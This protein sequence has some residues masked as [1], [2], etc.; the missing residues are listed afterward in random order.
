MTTKLDEIFV[1]FTEEVEDL[2]KSHSKDS[3]SYEFEASY[4]ILMQEFGRSVFQS[5]VGDIPKSKNDRITILTSM[6]YICFPKNHLLATT[7]GG[8][9]ISPFLQEHLCRVGTKLIFEEASEEVTQLM[10]VEV[11]AKQIE[12]ICHHYGELLEQVDWKQALNEATELP[13]PLKNEQTYAM[14]DGSMILTREE[15]S[16]WKPG[17]ALQDL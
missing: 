17:Q 15:D 16:P 9:K 3:S 13:L 2:L 12:C 7:P 11:N 5:L 6:G 1:V 8:F 10:G 14:I 4:N